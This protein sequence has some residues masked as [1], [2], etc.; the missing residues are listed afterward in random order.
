MLK[1]MRSFS[2]NYGFILMVEMNIPIGNRFHSFLDKIK[3]RNR[4]TFLR[5]TSGRDELS[6]QCECAY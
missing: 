2:F 6:K 3:I 5:G 1:H 4:N